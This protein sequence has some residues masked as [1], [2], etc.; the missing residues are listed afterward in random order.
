MKKIKLMALLLVSPLLCSFTSYDSEKIVLEYHSLYKA[1]YILD[2][3]GN[4]IES[5]QK[6]TSGLG[7][8]Y[9][10]VHNTRS[11]SV[12]VGY[13]TLQPNESVSV[14]L[15]TSGAIGSSVASFKNFES[16]AS[17]SVQHSGIMYN[18]ERFHFTTLERPKDDVYVT[19][20]LTLSK[21]NELS[22]IIKNQNNNYNLIW[23]NCAHFATEIW[24]KVTN[25][26]YYNGWFRDP[27]AICNE[28]RSDYA[29]S[30]KY[31]NYAL[32]P[33]DRFQYYDTT[34]SKMVTLV[35]DPK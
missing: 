18:Y 21:L 24:N 25:K 22:T 4:N 14:G 1:V 30:Y 9:I 13:Y 12:N 3:Y 17:A 8:S 27:G 32:K 31:G 10:V 26:N 16:S 35:Y 28:I 6:Y 19:A 15:W 7:H 34:A 20:D 11:T 33:L 5:Q 23:Y 2:S 29:T